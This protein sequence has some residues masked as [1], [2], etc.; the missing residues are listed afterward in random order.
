M[1]RQ[2]KKTPKKTPQKKKP[3]KFETHLKRTFSIFFNHTRNC[4][5]FSLLQ[6]HV[7]GYNKIWKVHKVFKSANMILKPYTL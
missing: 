3:Q 2:K 7:N 1:I 5:F 6:K 4:T